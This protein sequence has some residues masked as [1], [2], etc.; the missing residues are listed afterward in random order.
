MS[1]ST[2]IA[3]SH[4][5]MGCGCLLHSHNGMCPSCFR[6]GLVATRH[7]RLMD[8]LRPQGR[9]VTAKQLLGQ[10]C[11]SFSPRAYPSLKL[12]RPA[13]VMLSG[14]AG[15]G[16]TGWMLKAAD[17]LTPSIFMPVEMGAGAVLADYCRRLEIAADDLRFVE[18]DTQADLAAWAEKGSTFVID[19]LTAATVTPVDIERITRGNNLLTIGSLHVTKDGD[20]AGSGS[21]IHSADVAIHVENRRWTL[22]KSRF[23]S[24]ENVGGEV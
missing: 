5:C 8:E 19:S 2:E 13:F 17:C 11:S 15:G 7:R 16:K 3:Y 1:T 21:W 22:V 12:C 18:A 6:T 14:P 9:I 20:F 23:Q 24:V 4:V 10:T